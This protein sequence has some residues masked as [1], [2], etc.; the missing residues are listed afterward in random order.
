[1]DNPTT[2]MSLLIFFDEASMYG[3]GAIFW[4]YVGTNAE[5]LCT[6]FCNFK[7]Y[8]VLRSVYLQLI[9]YEQGSS[10]LLQRC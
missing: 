8:H 6:K 1:M 10:N 4:G 3:D 9:I 2:F 5:P 7:Q